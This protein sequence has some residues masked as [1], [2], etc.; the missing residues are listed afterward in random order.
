E[1]Q[2]AH[3]SYGISFFALFSIDR[4]ELVVTIPSD[5]I[6]QSRTHV[7][8]LA[9]VHVLPRLMEVDRQRPGHLVLPLQNGALC[10]PERHQEKQDAFLIYG[11]QPRWEDVPLLPCC[12][13]VREKDQ[14]ALLAIAA[15]G[16]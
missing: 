13:V 4:G 7:A 12:R 16:E 3:G 15:S 10:Y 11:Q 2:A 8:L 1:V 6:R 14:A 5:R 9:G